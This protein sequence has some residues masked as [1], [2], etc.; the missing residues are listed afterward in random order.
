MDKEVFRSSMVGEGENNSQFN[1]FV[2]R[3]TTNTVIC[4]QDSKCTHINRK[5]A[6]FYFP[7][8]EAESRITAK[9]SKEARR[10]DIQK[11]FLFRA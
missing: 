2:V 9:N 3:S 6:I 1:S 8:R 10:A 5:N 11:C 7:S 4:C